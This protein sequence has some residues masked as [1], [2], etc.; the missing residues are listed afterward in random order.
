M[1]ESSNLNGVPDIIEMLHIHT[2]KLEQHGATLAEM[3]AHMYKLDE[4][5]AN[6]GKLA[7]SVE[8]ALARVFTMLERRED[9]SRKASLFVTSILGLLLVILALA[10]T[11]FELQAG[12][13][14]GHS[15]TLKE[16]DGRNKIP[17]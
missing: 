2:H 6:T 7:S 13:K 16:H 5:A 4:I 11:K 15:I 12:S 3:R 8:N 14:D 1:G 10:V 9:T 17:D